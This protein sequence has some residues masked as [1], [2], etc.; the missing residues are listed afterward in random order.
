MSLTFPAA[1]SAAL[2]S[3]AINETW[4]F[5][6]YY[7]DETNFVGISSVDQTVSSKQYYGIV[8]DPGTI[9]RRIILE[10]S[11][12]E[13]DIVTVRCINKWKK[14]SFSALLYGGSN[15]FI[16]RKVKIY[17]NV[18]EQTNIANCALLFQG[19]LIRISH[20]AE[21]VFLE[22]EQ[23]RP[24]D[25]MAIPYTKSISG[26]YAPVVYGD[27]VQDTEANFY[28]SKRLYPSP[29]LKRE[30][31]KLWHI[32][33]DG[34]TGDAQLFFYDKNIDKFIPLTTVD[35]NS[36]TFG[37]IEITSTDTDL[38]RTFRWR[39]T[40]QG[41]G[42]EFSNAVSSY[43]EDGDG[44]SNETTYALYPSSGKHTVTANGSM[45]TEDYSLKIN[46]PDPDGRFTAIAIHAKIDVFGD[47]DDM[48]FNGGNSNIQV[49]NQTLNDNVAFLT[50]YLSEVQANGSDYTESRL[51]T[52]GLSIL[53]EYQAN[54]NK[55]G[56]IE[57]EAVWTA[58]YYDGTNES[59]VGWV[60]IFDVFLKGTA[61]LDFNNE[62]EASQKVLESLN[63]L[64][65]GAD[66]F[67]QSYTDGSGVADQPH[68]I[69]RDLIKR[70]CGLDYDNDYMQGFSS[71]NQYL[72]SD[73]NS[74]RSGWTCHW[75]QLEPRS[76]T[77]ILEQI[78]F[79]GC[80]IFFLVHDSD[81]SGN[82][83][84]KYIWVHNSYASGDVSATLDEDDYGDLNISMTD[85]KDLVTKT[86]YEYD[87]H[88]AKDIRMERSTYSNPT[89]RAAGGGSTALW[90][91]TPNANENHQQYE[92]EFITADK[93]YNSGLHSN[94]ND[95][96]ALYYNNIWG[97]PK[98]KV[99][100]PVVNPAKFNLEIGDILKYNDSNIDPY[101]K[102]WSD[103]Y[104][105]IIEEDRSPG[106]LHILSEEVYES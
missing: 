91:S 19:K 77:E 45:V 2:K 55:L 7:A 73:L 21:E 33:H 74:E 27:F 54:D 37:L 64:Y 90:P 105:M 88:P 23:N 87:R 102:T 15:A 5:Q 42:N 75:W 101:G 12:S 24:W 13:T 100:C 76:L 47:Y 94:P 96:V 43:D 9:K 3:S 51:S 25:D 32:A 10:E 11:R 41:A 49:L 62:P 40:A 28:T 89:S 103:L 95:C 82:S 97:T 59:V 46:A 38:E 48:V 30:T 53:T 80:F 26:P 60:R 29:F 86:S 71:D 18:N 31:N 106:N 16:N 8:S 92:L 35:A 85:F 63:F 99:E 6:L 65:L 67:S 34:L 50:V 22:I 4:L 52:T 66:G 81:G 72:S 1:Y 56:V 68:E 78:Q 69:H 57:I 104:F 17:S 83:G 20:T 14:D 84:G 98:I 79:E 36:T 39:P 70:F 44:S 58:Y 93:V 61:S